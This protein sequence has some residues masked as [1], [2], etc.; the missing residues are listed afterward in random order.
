MGDNG[1]V[2]KAEDGAPFPILSYGNGPGFHRLEV[3]EG[4][5]RAGEAPWRAIQRS[6]ELE[7]GERGQPGHVY[8]GAVPLER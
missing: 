1:W 7:V 5:P 2:F 3:R 8:P 6:E 4:A